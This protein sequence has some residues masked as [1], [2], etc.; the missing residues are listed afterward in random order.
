MELSPVPMTSNPGW[1][2]MNAFLEVDNV[3]KVQ[4]GSEAAADLQRSQTINQQ[5]MDNIFMRSFTS[6]P[7]NPASDNVVQATPSQGNEINDVINSLSYRL[8][9]HIVKETGYIHWCRTV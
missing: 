8:G 4:N 3:G 5:M 7:K 9:Y 2:A 6:K 1:K